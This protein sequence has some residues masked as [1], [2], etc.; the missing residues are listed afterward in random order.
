MYRVEQSIQVTEDWV[1][2]QN[3]ARHVV[4]A[5][6]P[7]WTSVPSDQIQANGLNNLHFH[8]STFLVRVACV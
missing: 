7:S 1:S 2:L 5:L 3:D 6:L 4:K 8:K